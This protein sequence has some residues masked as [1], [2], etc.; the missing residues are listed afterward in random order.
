MV[1]FCKPLLLVGGDV[2]LVFAA[3]LVDDRDNPRI[4]S[5]DGHD[6]EHSH[7]TSTNN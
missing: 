6:G 5:G 3:A 1:L 7:K 2:G 4:K